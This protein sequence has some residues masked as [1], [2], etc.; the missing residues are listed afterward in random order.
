M[1]GDYFKNISSACGINMS[2]EFKIVDKYNN[3]A[4]EK[5]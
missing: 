1:G 5:A 3:E 4:I 2:K